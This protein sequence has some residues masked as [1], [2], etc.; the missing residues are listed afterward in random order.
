MRSDKK[1]GYRAN[2]LFGN[3]QAFVEGSNLTRGLVSLAADAR[4]FAHTTI[5]GLF[6]WS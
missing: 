5:D 6:S 1:F 3:G 2:A 4:P